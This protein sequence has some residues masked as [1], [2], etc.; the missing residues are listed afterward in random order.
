MRKWKIL[1][2]IAVVIMAACV[3]CCIGGI[4]I[5]AFRGDIHYPMDFGGV[6]VWNK[7]EHIKMLL[8]IYLYILGIPFFAG[9]ILYIVSFLRIRHRGVNGDSTH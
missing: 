3:L 1:R 8:G 4:S 9:F 7:T 5:V 6:S 2:T